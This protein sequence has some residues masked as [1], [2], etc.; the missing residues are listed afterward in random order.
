MHNLAR[1]HMQRYD[2]GSRIM[3]PITYIRG[4]ATKP[5]GNG[6]KI[7]AHICNDAGLFGAGFAL[8]VAKR[9]PIAR[10]YYHNW[11]KSRA[12]FFL[13]AVAVLIVEPDIRIAHM[14]AQH[15][16]RSASNRVP[17]RYDALEQCLLELTVWST[18]NGAANSAT[19]HMPRIG[20]GLAGSTWNRIEPLIAKTLCASDISVT[21]Y[22]P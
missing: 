15:G 1:T 8:A 20:C 10:D 14:I 13:G 3:T 22:D 4:D 16:V 18:H 2:R 12:G 19:V 21:V 11:F 6:H 7:V 5:I 17:I 9:W